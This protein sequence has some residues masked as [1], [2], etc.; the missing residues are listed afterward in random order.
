M[1]RNEKIP[2]RREFTATAAGTLATDIYVGDIKTIYAVISPTN[3]INGRILGKVGLKGVYKDIP[4][5]LTEGETGAID[6]SGVEYIAFVVDS[7]SKDTQITI[8][9]YEDDSRPDVVKMELSSD[10]ND[11]RIALDNNESL[12]SIDKELKKLNKYMSIIV[13]DEL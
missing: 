13:G 2:F 10:S 5:T 8:F 4:F 3:S 1:A 12:K 9:G 11:I 6:I 7:I